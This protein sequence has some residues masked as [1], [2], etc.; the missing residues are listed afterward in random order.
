MVDGNADGSAGVEGAMRR[1]LLTV[2]AALAAAVPS[3]AARPTTSPP[4][5]GLVTYADA[6]GDVWVVQAG[7][8]QRRRLTR[9]GPEVD[10]DPGFRSDGSEVVFRSTRGRQPPDPYGIGLDALFR[11]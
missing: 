4:L 6:R 2:L 7:G 3:A 9:S 10:F 5:R 8:G 11:I 1:S